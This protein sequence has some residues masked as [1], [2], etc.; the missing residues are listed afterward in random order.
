M[1]HK[2]VDILLVEDSPADAY[3]VQQALQNTLVHTLQV[4]QD[5]EEAMT[6]MEREG[7]YANAF[8]PDLILLDLNLP[9]RNGL[10]VLAELKKNERYRQIP[11]IVLTTSAAASDIKQAYQLSASCY[12]T[13]PGDFDQFVHVVKAIKSFWCTVVTLPMQ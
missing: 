9:K 1:S 13:K 8:T 4:V 10:W 5:G 6:F 2:P 7:A 12:I 11:V 3:F